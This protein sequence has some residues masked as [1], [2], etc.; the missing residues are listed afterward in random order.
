VYILVLVHLEED[1]RKVKCEVYPLEGLEFQF[2]FDKRLE[3]QLETKIFEQI[4]D[5]EEA[6]VYFIYISYAVVL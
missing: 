6:H 4:V 3:F 2:F 5:G 1:V